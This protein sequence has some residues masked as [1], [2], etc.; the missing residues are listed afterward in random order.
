M[1]LKKFIN[2]YRTNSRLL[3]LIK[4]K[5][6]VQL[7]V[8]FSRERDGQTSYCQVPFQEQQFK[9]REY[10]A[11]S[12]DDLRKFLNYNQKKFMTQ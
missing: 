12:L 3:E 11:Q 6:Y 10:L 9:Q 4:E 2:D 1:A 8:Q 7:K 5:C